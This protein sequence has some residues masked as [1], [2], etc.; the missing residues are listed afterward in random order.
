MTFIVTYMKV[1]LR[2]WTLEPNRL[3]SFKSS[4]SHILPVRRGKLLSFSLPQF[5][6][7]EARDNYSTYL[8][9]VRVVNEWLPSK[10]WEQ[11]LA[12]HKHSV[13]VGHYY[14]YH[15]LLSSL[16]AAKRK[17]GHLWLAESIVLSFCRCLAG[18]FCALMVTV[19]ADSVLGNTL[20]KTEGSASL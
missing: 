18:G 17:D 14:F 20:S 6:H 19:W 1:W 9:V 2:I 8:V 11:S 16:Q 5:P 3:T 12:Y 10:H 7:P 4:P 13:S 15:N